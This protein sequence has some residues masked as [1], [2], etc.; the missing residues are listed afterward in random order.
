MSQKQSII[1]LNEVA[2][3]FKSSGRST[4]ALKGISLTIYK[5][6]SVLISGE[7]GSGKTTLLK[8]I[9]LLDTPTRGKIIINGI[10][11]SS[12][13]ENDRAVVRRKTIGFIFQ[14]YHLQANLTA[15]ENVMLPQILEGFTPNEARENSL[16]LLDDF[17]LSAKANEPVTVLSGGEAQRV[18]IARAVSLSPQI[19]LADEPTGNL[20]K[21]TENK[22]INYI[23]EYTKKTCSSLV[24]VSHNT[25]LA[26]RLERHF[27]LEHGSLTD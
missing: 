27:I 15:I 8:L 1:E 21:E 18:A 17:G 14:K 25:D 26:S 24:M 22:V 13:S 6:E 2:K 12:R 16:M 20:D 11:Y 7:S 9:G 3:S 10:D 23:L 19:I 5:G 4:E